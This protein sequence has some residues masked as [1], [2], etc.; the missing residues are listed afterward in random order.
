M[1]SNRLIRDVGRRLLP[2]RVWSRLRVLRVKHDLSTYEPRVVSHRYGD[3]QLSVQLSDSMGE[4]WY[5]SDWNQLPEIPLLRQ[6]RLRKGALVF[7]LG[8]HHGVVALML[9][10]EVGEGGRVVAVEASPHNAAV[11]RQNVVLNKAHHVVVEQVAVLDSNG[12]ASFGFGHNGQLDDGTGRYGRQSVAA[13]T[14]D[15]LTERYG[16]PDVI[17]VDVEGAECLVLD[18]ALQTMTTRPDWA[19]EVHSGCGLEDFGGSTEELLAR[20]LDAGYLV[21]VHTQT[22]PTPF[23]ITEPTDAPQ[24]RIFLTATWN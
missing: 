23:P 20:F 8:A 6:S 16:A 24:G 15:T 14:V 1:A 4:L 9:G 19:V 22:D 18:G 21:H 12:E 2:A 10:A 3:C 13:I 7:D 5:D 11:A 17:L